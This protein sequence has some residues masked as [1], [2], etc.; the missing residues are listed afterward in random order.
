MT[1]VLIG[2]L[3]ILEANKGKLLA[4]VFE[5]ISEVPIE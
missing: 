4:V 5:I 3:L 2:I 1:I